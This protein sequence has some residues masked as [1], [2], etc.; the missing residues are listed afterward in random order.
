MPSQK[1]LNGVTHDIAHHAVSGLSYIHPYL[2]ELCRAMKVI[3]IELNIL[4]ECP[5][6]EGVV[7]IEPLE[8]ASKGLHLEFVR[9]LERNGFS[10]ADVQV[11]TLAFSFYFGPRRT[12]DYCSSCK[13]TL[14]TS[15][16]KK[17][18]QVVR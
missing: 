5:L 9:I 8:L 6:P 4:K 11:A 17:F 16:G 7:P 2:G 12:D 18:E 13:A 14:V 15:Q 10:L 1:L 3:H